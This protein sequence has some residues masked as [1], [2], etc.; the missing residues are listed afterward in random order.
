MLIWLA[1]EVGVIPFLRPSTSLVDGASGGSGIG[2]YEVD[3]FVGGLF[4]CHEG[5]GLLAG[6]H[7]VEAVGAGEFS[8]CEDILGED[9]VEEDGAAG[10]LRPETL[11]VRGHAEAPG[12]AAFARIHFDAAAIRFETHDA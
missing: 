10:G 9:S 4:P 8:F 3:L 2:A 1:G 7:A 12:I 11:A 5:K 6:D